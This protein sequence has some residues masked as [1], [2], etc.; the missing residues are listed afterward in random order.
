[1]AVKNGGIAESIAKMTFGNKLG[2]DV[3]AQLDENDWFR[4]NYGAFIVE[5]AENIEHK[6]AML[7]GKVIDEARN[8]IN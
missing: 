7:L 1:M 6:N 2:V 3:S 5:T 8:T 4:V